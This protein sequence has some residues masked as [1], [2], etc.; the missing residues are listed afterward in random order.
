MYFCVSMVEM[1]SILPNEVA[2]AKLHGYLLGAIGPRPIAFASTIDSDGKPNLSPFSFFNVFSANPPI[3]IFS[4]ARRV[5]DNTTKHTLHNVFETKEVVI[6]VVDFSIVQQM[7]LAS[8]EYP[9]GENEFLKAGLTML[10]SDLV[11][12]FRVAEAPVQFECR[13]TKVEALGNEGGAGNL[14][15]CEVLKIHVSKAILDENGSIDQHKIDLVARMGGNWYSRANLGLFEVTKP[16]STLG[17]GIDALPDHIKLSPIL[18][19]NDLGMLANIEKI[20]SLEEIKNLPALNVDLN[21]VI[22]SGDVIKLHQ[23]AQEYLYKN[24]VLS[25]WKVL[26]S[27]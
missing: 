18:T 3:L 20:P 8:T 27:N 16:L 26:L 12:P 10:A 17:I 14:V 1:I 9:D 23:T 25:A 24:D 4:P 11:K 22:K 7:S 13:V 15:F 21:A 5:R 19:G 6:N 2:T